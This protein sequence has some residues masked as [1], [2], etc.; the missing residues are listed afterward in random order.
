MK[1]KMPTKRDLQAA[2]TRQKIYDTA[3]R[4]ITEKGFEN[5]TIEEISKE[6]G[7][8]K[9]LFYHYFKSKE[10]IVIETYLIIDEKFSQFYNKN[11]PHCNSIEKILLA[12]NFQA[13]HATDLGI[14]FVRQIYKSQLDSGTQYFISKERPFYKILM[15]AIRAAQ[16]D[17]TIR[18]DVS[19]SELTDLIL[20]CSRGMLYD[21]CLHDGQYELKDRMINQLTLILNGMHHG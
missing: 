9:G 5:V 3:F 15:E 18:D 19:P 4:L 6:S 12:A 16:I 1:G 11:S 13:L 20:S 17:G 7:V 2:E 21:W 8:A 10:D 14:D